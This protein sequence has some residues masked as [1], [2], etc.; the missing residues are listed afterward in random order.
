MMTR[1]TATFV[2]ALVMVVDVWAE[3]KPAPKDIPTE[4]PK[5]KSDAPADEASKKVFDADYDAGLVAL[6]DKNW[7]LVKSKMGSALKA[8]GE[9]NDARKSTAQILLNKAERL[10]IKDDALF[11]AGELVRLK[12]WTEAEEAYRK[13]VDVNGETETL[14][15]SI[16]ACRAGIE[17]E[18]EGLKKAG[19]LL[20]E[21]K[22]KDAIDAFNKV[23][24][25]LGG[26]RIIR[27]GI[28]SANLG[29]ESDELTKKGAA[30]L[31]DKKW[32][33][34]F[35]VYKRLLQIVGETDDVRKGIAASQA[36]YA[37]D[38]KATGSSES[39]LK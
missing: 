2:L 29:I 23:S 15:T 5:K 8:L 22:W 3:E 6:N 16:M 20:K 11:T 12:Q 36:G 28:N 34:A 13:V 19:E 31:K 4:A 10:L 35:N 33:D 26:I 1:F 30:F 9:A 27:D 38:H 37:E 32:D 14:R 21:R 17:G 18:N 24:D 7:P 25:K 39:L